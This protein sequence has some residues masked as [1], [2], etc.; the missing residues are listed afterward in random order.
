MK[1]FVASDIHSFLDELIAGLQEAG[2]DIADPNHVLVI[3]GDLFDRGP[4]SVE[5]FDF[6]MSIPKERL[7]LIEGNHELLFRSLMYRDEPRSYDF[8]NGTVS[9]YCQIADMPISPVL[10]WYEVIAAPFSEDYYGP[11]EFRKECDKGQKYWDAIKL[12]VEKSSIGRA[13]L[14][15]KTFRKYLEI[16]PYIITH[17]FIPTLIHGDSWR[18]NQ[19]IS[20]EEAEWG[21]PFKQ[22]EAGLFLDE[23]AEGKIL[24][25][26]HWYASDFHVRY[27]G[28]KVGADNS[29]YCGYHLIA[30]DGCTIRSGL[31]NVIVID[32][33]DWSIA[34]RGQ[35]LRPKENNKELDI[36]KGRFGWE[37]PNN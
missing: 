23:M 6:L 32:D 9:T 27:E 17:S 34:Y 22:Y 35:P 15:E 10:D 4:K 21:C 30:I 25:C 36:M 33:E 14:N 28:A 24:I 3:D 18:D 8:S 19:D 12:K 1:Y 37:E 7:V 29:V 26:G 20:W 31:C 5:L 2:F 16:G 13:V 11:E